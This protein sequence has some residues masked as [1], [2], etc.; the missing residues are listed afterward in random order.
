MKLPCFCTQ[1]RFW[2]QQGSPVIHKRPEHGNHL[3][4]FPV[5]YCSLIADIVLGS[6][7]QIGHEL[8]KGGGEQGSVIDCPPETVTG[9]KQ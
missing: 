1:Q 4:L 7:S 5:T 8:T 9:Q 2:P 3:R 6:F